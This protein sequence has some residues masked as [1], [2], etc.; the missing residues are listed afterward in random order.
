LLRDPLLLVILGPTGSGK[1]AL[2]L[3]LAQH[4]NGEIVNCDS[5]AIYREFFIGTAKPTE[6]WFFEVVNAGTLNQ[7]FLLPEPA[8]AA[9]LTCGVAASSLRRIGRRRR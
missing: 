2:S 5:V 6:S 8:S 9:L 3:R 7:Q 4:F 1:T